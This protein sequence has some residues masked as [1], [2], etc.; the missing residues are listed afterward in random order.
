MSPESSNLPTFC[1]LVT[2]TGQTLH[3]L[4]IQD[5]KLWLFD[6]FESEIR[7]QGLA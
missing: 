4:A 7:D 3:K 2:D 6:A 5:F 1:K